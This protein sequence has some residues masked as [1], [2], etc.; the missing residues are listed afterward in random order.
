[1]ELHVNGGGWVTA[2]GW[3]RLGEGG[4]P[5]LAAGDPRIP[6]PEEIYSTLPA[7][8]RRFDAYCQ[9]GCAAI[10]LALKDAGLSS[11]GLRQP[12]GVIA[13]SRYGCFETDL[14]YHATT[15]QADGTFAS[16]T[17]FSYTLPGIAISE[18]AIHFGLTGPL[19]TIGGDEGPAGRHALGIAVDLLGSGACP[20]VLAGW[21]DA[22]SRRLRGTAA[23][24]DGLRGAAFVVLSTRRAAGRSRP[25]GPGIATAPGKSLPSILE[26]LA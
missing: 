16:P 15:R 18:A 22:A 21:I 1:M 14:A 17:L 3:G 4:R 5:V 23:G 25:A 2:G 24:D 12:I 19:L 7:R 9:I 8:Y 26:L 6:P 10:A 20:A 13:S 11:D